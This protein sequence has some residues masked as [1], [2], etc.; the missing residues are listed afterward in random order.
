MS[1]YPPPPWWAASPPPSTSSPPGGV[2][3]HSLDFALMLD[4]ALNKLDRI[5]EDVISIKHR[6]EDGDQR[7]DDHQTRISVLEAKPAAPPP[8]PPSSAPP[9]EV[10]I[11]VATIAV[12][13]LATL[14]Y[15]GSIEKAL[16]ILRATKALP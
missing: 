13:P 1:S 11:K 15:T 2:N 3:G 14:L 16:D 12:L 10:W 8:A 7:M 4:R 5:A 6:L 9:I